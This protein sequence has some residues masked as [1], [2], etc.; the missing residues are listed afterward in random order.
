[1]LTL[2]YFI[3]LKQLFETSK[4]YYNTSIDTIIIESFHKRRR[5][6]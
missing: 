6:I 3:N 2:H 1:M 4:Q 5:H